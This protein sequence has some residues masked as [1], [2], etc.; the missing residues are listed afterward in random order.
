VH[1]AEHGARRVGANRNQAEV[2]GAPQGADLSKGGADGEVCVRGGVVVDVR[3]E[4]GDGAVAGVAVVGV[5]KWELG[6][7]EQY[8]PSEP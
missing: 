1:G 4:G 8:G 7:E 3:G 2:K 6:G 5:S